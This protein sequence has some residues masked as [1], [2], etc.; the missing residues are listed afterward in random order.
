MKHIYILYGPPGSGK[1]TILEKLAEKITQDGNTPVLFEMGQAMRDFAA[2]SGTMVAQ[3]VKQY[4][5][6]GISLPGVIPSHFWINMIMNMKEEG[7]DKRVVILEGVIRTTEEGLLLAQLAK[8]VNVPVTI[9]ELASSDEVC[10]ER[11]ASRGR[12]DD[13]AKEVVE[14]RLEVYRKGTIDAMHNLYV[15]LVELN[16]FTKLEKIDASVEGAENVWKQVEERLT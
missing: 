2:N 15:Q 7:S 9:F 11:L 1:G 3:V 13:Q 12:Y 10:I 5:A 4:Q 8:A 16:V 6:E 14:K